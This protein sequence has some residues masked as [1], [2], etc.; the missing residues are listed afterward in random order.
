MII[1]AYQHRTQ[2]ELALLGAAVPLCDAKGAFGPPV[3]PLTPYRHLLL[4]GYD[5]PFLLGGPRTLPAVLQYLWICGPAF[6]LGA[7]W[8]FR[9]F[10]WRWGRRLGWAGQPSVRVL[11]AIETHLNQAILDRPPL[12]VRRRPASAAPEGMPDCPH[13]LAALEYTCRKHLQYTAH[14]F[15]H[16][17]FGHTYQL[18][19]LHVGHSRPDV[20]RFDRTRDAAKG[21]HLRA[22]L[23]R[24]RA[25][26]PPTTR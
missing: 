7:R 8:R 5:S 26:A 23:A 6:R 3:Y 4:L 21:A 9:L 25:G 2:R 20:P 12:P 24:L 16:T 14:E 10:A 13:E 18:L 1:S 11:A 15:W 17:P 19:S 22:R